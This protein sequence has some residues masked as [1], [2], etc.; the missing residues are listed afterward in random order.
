MSTSNVSAEQSLVAGW[1]SQMWLGIAPDAN[2]VTL[3]VMSSGCTKKE[4]FSFLIT[5][6]SVI[7]II[8]VRADKCRAMPKP[9]EFHYSF[10]ELGISETVYFNIEKQ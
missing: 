2:E 4:D 10:I 1:Q 7:N 5:D 8:R 3:R 6:E 9:I